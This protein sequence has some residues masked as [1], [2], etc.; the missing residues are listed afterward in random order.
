MVADLW[1]CGF[2]GSIP[3]ETHKPLELLFIRITVIT[4]KHLTIYFFKFIFLISRNY[5]WPSSQAIVFF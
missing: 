5:I 1:H 3:K 4:R 2:K